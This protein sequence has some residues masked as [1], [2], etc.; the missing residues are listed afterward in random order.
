[1]FFWSWWHNETCPF[2]VPL[3]WL[4][5]RNL[6]RYPYLGDEGTMEHPHPDGSLIVVAAN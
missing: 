5:G 3:C 6:D 4:R 1:M 2:T